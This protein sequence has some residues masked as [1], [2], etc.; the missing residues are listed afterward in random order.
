MNPRQGLRSWTLLGAYV[1]SRSPAN[2]GYAQPMLTP[3]SRRCSGTNIFNGIVPGHLVA[4]STIVRINLFLL[5]VSF[6]TSCNV[7]SFSMASLNF[8]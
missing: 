7:S 3:K 8:S 2:W 6:F 4:A 1:V 5:F